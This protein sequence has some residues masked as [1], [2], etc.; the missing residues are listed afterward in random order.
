MS[1]YQT[2]L[3]VF[4]PLFF[5]KI[6]DTLGCSSHYD[7][8]HT[9]AAHTDF[10]TKPGCSKGNFLSETFCDLFFVSLDCIQLCSQVLISFQLVFPFL[11]HLHCIHVFF[12]ILFCFF[13]L[14]YFFCYVSLAFRY[15]MLYICFLFIFFRD[16]LCNLFP[17]LFAGC[18]RF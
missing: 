18:H 9:V 17:C 12:S 6:S 7:L 15:P 1:D 3:H 10:P 13:I 11:I 14:L 2:T 8:I 5:D 4:L 16:F